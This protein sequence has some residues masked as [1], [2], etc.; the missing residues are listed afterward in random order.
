MVRKGS[1]AHAEAGAVRLPAGALCAQHDPEL[2]FPE[3]VTDKRAA[4]SAVAAAK[5]VCGLCPIRA[6]CLETALAD[7][8]ISGIWGGTTAAERDRVR[9]ARRGALQV[10]A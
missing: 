7:R 6:T 4:A 9:L 5:V 8:R 1:T 3:D 2:F 10:G